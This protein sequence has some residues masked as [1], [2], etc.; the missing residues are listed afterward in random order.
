MKRHRLTSAALAVAMSVGASAM[1]QEKLSLAI[2]SG[3]SDITQFDG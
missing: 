3:I 1:A 2:V